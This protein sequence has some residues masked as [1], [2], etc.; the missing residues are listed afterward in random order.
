MSGESVKPAQSGH[1]LELLG[2]RGCHLC[3]EAEKLLQI[4]ARTRGVSWH[5]RD[6][7]ESDDLVANYGTRIPVLRA[8]EREIN[9]PFGLLD[10]LR[11][12]A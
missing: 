9:W 12:L 11:F 10:I 1:A 5:Y 7:A 6:I 4:A 3:D 8:G 2:T